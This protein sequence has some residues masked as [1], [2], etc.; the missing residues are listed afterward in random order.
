MII[1]FFTLCFPNGTLL[2]CV[3]Y[4]N[5]LW[6]FQP[7]PD[8]YWFPVVTPTYCNDTITI[9]ENFGQWSNGANNVRLL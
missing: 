9:M 7:C 5:M 2:Q 6:S 1:L 4:A 3:M 8:V